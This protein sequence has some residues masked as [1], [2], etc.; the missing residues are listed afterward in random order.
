MRVSEAIAVAYFL[1]LSIAAV[2]VRLPLARR[3][4]VW[5]AAG[6]VIAIEVVA[7]R[8]PP[9][10]WVEQVRDWLPALVI[11]LAY[12]VTGLFYVRPSRRVESWL[13]SWDEWLLGGWT[14]RALPRVVRN[15]FDLVYDA[16]FLV[17]PA[18]FAVLAWSGRSARADRYWTLVSAAEYLA[19]ATL[20]WLQARPPWAIEAVRA[21]D[22]A[23]VRRFSLSWVHHT[24]IRANTFPSGHASA[25][26]SA[27]LAL[28][29]EVPWAG[30]VFTVLAVS[31]AVGSVVGRFH[32]AID[33]IAGLLLAL[34]LAA[35]TSSL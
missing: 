18:G 12:F 14:P 31:I 27:A 3:A 22:H 20:P 11:L 6:A 25:S 8:T 34:A 28:W 1:Y 13:Q 15:Y 21:A 7:S 17:V 16:C 35:A 26:F 19:F 10:Q 33:A 2:I 30:A 29:S 23:G 4:P 24:T 32:Y 5:A 9:S